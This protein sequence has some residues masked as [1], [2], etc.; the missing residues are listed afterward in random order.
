M[1]RL[2]IVGLAVVASAF[3]AA[4]DDPARLQPLSPKQLAPSLD[5][6]ATGGEEHRVTYHGGEQGK[7]AIDG[8]KIVWVDWRRAGEAR[9]VV[10]DLSDHTEHRLPPDGAQS[11]VPSISSG[12]V[13]W[14]D[15]GRAGN[16]FVYDLSTSTEQQITSGP[17]AIRYRPDISGDR[18]VWL[19]QPLAGGPGAIYV[20]ESSAGA[21]RRITSADAQPASDPQISGDIVVYVDHRTGNFDIFAY[22]LST[23]TERQIT[24]SPSN[25]EWPDVSGSRI[26]WSRGFDIYSYDLTTGAE[27]R[28][29]A[30]PAVDQRPAISGD[31]VAWMSSPP[32]ES[33]SIRNI[34]TYDLSTGVKRQV[35]A[36]GL[37]DVPISV[38]GARIVWQDHRDGNGEI[39][40]YGPPLVWPEPP[41]DADA[42][43]TPDVEDN[44]PVPN[45]NQSDMDRDGIGDICDPTPYPDAD[46]D[47]VFDFNDNCP[48][49]ANPDQADNDGNGFGDACD[50]STPVGTNVTA[51]PVD[52]TTGASP[53]SISFGFVSTEGETSVTTSTSGTAPPDGFRLGS[54]PVYYEIATTATFSGTAT[55]CITYDPSAFGDPSNLRLLHQE[56]G[57]WTDVTLPGYPS[58]GVVCGE[59][60]SFSPFTVVEQNTPPVITSIALPSDPV[61]VGTTISVRAAFTD[62]GV[63]DV[64]TAVVDW[65]GVTGPATLT[66]TNG[67]GSAT[68]TRVLT[69]PGVYTVG[70]A[71]SDGM[72]TTRRSSVVDAPAYVVVYDQA[73]GF[74]TGGG[75]INSPPGAYAADPALSGKASFG[76]VSRYQKGASVPSG[77]TEFQFKAGS[78][79]FASASYQWLVVAGARAQFKGEGTINGTGRYGFLLTAID[80]QIA[81]GGGADKFRIKIWSIASGQMVYDNKMG[82]PEDSDA[83][84]ALGGGSILIHK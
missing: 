52:P 77:N 81:G 22:D 64:H 17:P 15:Y 51:R 5:L 35:S 12:R 20:Y 45:A 82:S 19:E 32:G 59:V 43:G 28:I 76:F 69:A 66:E 71:I 31:L 84:T 57:V 14:Q 63:R 21:A 26:V 10:Y 18:V 1:A 27:R 16:I 13:A 74:A 83:A 34:Y 49:V 73:G 3:L 2:A 54:R 58:G 55:V 70:V 33:G 80:G 42:D 29:T 50:G 37:A 75:W 24:S 68:A 61:V 53:A 44:C 25:D 39:Y 62:A 23:N 67:S 4:C 72:A 78:L 48:T 56:S 6:S 65:D 8:D 30:D 46:A 38:S 41:A 40:T 36:G 79:G 7:P 60:R 11:D 9:V 47:G